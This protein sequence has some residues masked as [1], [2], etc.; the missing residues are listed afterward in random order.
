MKAEAVEPAFVVFESGEDVGPG[1]LFGVIGVGA[2]EACLDECSFWLGKERGCGG[3]VVDEEISADGDNYGQKSFLRNVSALLFLQRRMV[4][5]TRMKIHRQPL[6][7][8]TPFINPIP[9]AKIPPKAPA[10]EA[11]EK[12]RATL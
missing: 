3:V 6:Y 11:A 4:G 1:E 10:S 9:Y 8:P 2:F 12:K 5:L 7:P